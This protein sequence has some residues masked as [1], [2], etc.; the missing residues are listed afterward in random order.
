[1]KSAL[2]IAYHCFA[3]GDA[4]LD[5]LILIDKQFMFLSVQ[6]LGVSPDWQNKIGQV[7]QHRKNIQQYRGL[8]MYNH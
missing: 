8:L 5:V 4:L 6:L 3:L 2:R 7:P 1:M